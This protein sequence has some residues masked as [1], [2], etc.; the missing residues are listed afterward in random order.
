[1]ISSRRL[2]QRNCCGHNKVNDDIHG[3]RLERLLSGDYHHS[4]AQSLFNSGR[5]IL[6]YGAG[7]NGRRVL[8]V[9][10]KRRY[11]VKGYID[12]NAADKRNSTSYPVLSLSEAVD[13]ANKD[14]FLIVIGVFHDQINTSAIVQDCARMG[15]SHIATFIHF[16]KEFEKDFGSAFGFSSDAVIM[17]SRGAILEAFSLL[18]DEASRKIF[19]DTLEFRLTGDYGSMPVPSSGV[20]YFDVSVKGLGR[21]DVFVDCGAYN[22]D[23]VE[24]LYKVHGKVSSIIAFEPDLHNFRQLLDNVG[25]MKPKPAEVFLPLPLG[26]WSENV[27]LKIS[28]GNGE[29]STIGESGTMT[30]QCVSIDSLLRDFRADLVKMD[31][32]GAEPYA[33]RGEAGLIRDSSPNQAICIYHQ[34]DHLWSILLLLHSLGG[35]YNYYL[36]AHRFNGFDTVLYAVK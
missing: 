1:M 5:E 24:D 7:G 12:K 29:T 4:D 25:R 19:V 18:C 32:E 23:T 15:F 22:G 9:L 3:R 21:P 30:V 11:R 10:E 14:S 6:I 20:R 26:L 17:Q 34:P 35:K 33:L 16:H 31:I 13:L 8:G 36:R 2:L 27:Q 28:E